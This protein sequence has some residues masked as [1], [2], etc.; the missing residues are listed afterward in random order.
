MTKKNKFPP[1]FIKLVLLLP[2][3][4]ISQPPPPPNGSLGTASNAMGGGASL[5]E[6]L[7]LVI[8]FAIGYTVWK[9]W[10]K[11]TPKYEIIQ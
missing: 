9:Y 6:A 8:V 4:A 7:I 5:D 1:L 11:K 10:R 3:S 2:I